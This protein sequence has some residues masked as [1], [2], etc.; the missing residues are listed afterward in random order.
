MQRT[1]IIELKPNKLQKAI[2]KELCLL[3]S[4]V[5]NSANYLIRQQFFNKEK[6]STF[7]DLQQ[8]LQNTVAKFKESTYVAKRNG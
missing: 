7:F 3:S 6:V 5:Y 4:C 8:K 1:N 2:L